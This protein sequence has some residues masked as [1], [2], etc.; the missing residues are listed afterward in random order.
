MLKSKRGSVTIV[1]YVAML[2]FAM[3]GIIIFS[4]SVTSYTVQTQAIENIQRAYTENATLE[5]M[6]SIYQLYST[7]IS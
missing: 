4:N 5:N 3:Y 7:P 2:F 6:Q 1:A